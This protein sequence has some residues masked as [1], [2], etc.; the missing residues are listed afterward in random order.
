MTAI[1]I[2]VVLAPLLV[3]GSSLATKKWGAGAGG[4]LLGLPLLSGP[5]SVMLLAERG[6]DFARHAARGTLLGLVATAAFCAA[7]AWASRRW[8]WWGSLLTGYAAFAVTAGAFSLLEPTLAASLVIASAALVALVFATRDPG[9]ARPAAP[10]PGWD[11]PVRVVLTGVLVVGV[12]LAAGHMGPEA[13]GLLAPLPVLG[14]IMAAFTHRRCG[15]AAA[16]GLMHGAVIGS[17]GGVAFF[18]VIVWLMGSVAPVAVYA[19][20]LCAAAAIGGLAMRVAA[21]RPLTRWLAG[22]TRRRISPQRSGGAS[23]A[24]APVA[25]LS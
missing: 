21:A 6:Q 9:E 20:A 15:A 17:W 2:R 19:L 8:P 10:A 25:R 12:S 5:I 3:G 13:A 24:L 23:I 22:R 11:L 1:L 4:W 7:Y 18:A 14:G 16:R